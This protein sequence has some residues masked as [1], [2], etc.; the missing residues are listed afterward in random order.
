[1]SND[2][3]VGLLRAIDF[4]AGLSD[5]DL[6]R[7]AETGSVHE[8][9]AG[10]VL[11]EH[12]KTGVGFHL[13][14]T[15]SAEVEVPGKGTFPMNRG[16]HFGEISLIDGAPRSATVRVGPEGATTFALTSWKFN[17]LL[18]KHP[19]IPMALLKSL[20]GRLRHAERLL[21]ERS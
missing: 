5:K 19:E 2:E 6:K 9:P 20:C 17:P 4:F 7:I 14:L 8:H 1:M 12:G 10:S 16:A 21:D 18:E 13:V 11:A 3:V 15:G